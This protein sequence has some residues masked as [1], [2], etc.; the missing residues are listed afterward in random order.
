VVADFGSGF[1]VTFLRRLLKKRSG[2][3]GIA[4]DLSLDP[5]LASDRLS[6]VVADL[7]KPLPLPDQSIDTATSLAVLEHLEQPE[8][9]VRELYRVLKSGGSLLLTTPTPAA[10]PV[11]ELISYR[12]HLIDAAE[13]RDHKHYFNEVELRALFEKVGFQPEQIRY[14]PFLVGLNQLIIATKL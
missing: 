12:L 1:D 9:Q 6:L 11:L 13:I 14:K 4:V 5:K 7:N 3:R 8:V 2:L 10:K